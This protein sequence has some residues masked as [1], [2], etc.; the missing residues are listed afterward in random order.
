MPQLERREGPVQLTWDPDTRLAVMRFVE[1]G[2]G[3]R[4]A[5]ETLSQQFDAWA[6]DEPFQVLVDC[7]DILDADAGWRAVWGEWVR[8][9]REIATLAWFNANARLRLLIL[10]FRKGTGVHGKAFDSEEEAR[11]WL[12]SQ[13]PP[14]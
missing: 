14:A 10:M 1:P 2:V 11:A 12:A 9:R 3:D 7:S 4:P 13:E 8:E 6:G 5:A